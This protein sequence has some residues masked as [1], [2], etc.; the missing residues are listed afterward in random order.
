[1]EC[2][3][4]TWSTG[5]GWSGVGDCNVFISTGADVCVAVVVVGAVAGAPAPGE[6]IAGLWDLALCSSSRHLIARPSCAL[7]VYCSDLLAVCVQPLT[8]CA[9]IR[10]AIA[11]PSWLVMDMV[12]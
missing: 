11:S 7:L 1:M 5:C 8:R 2:V 3:G 4:S 9:N 6:A 10:L 12:V